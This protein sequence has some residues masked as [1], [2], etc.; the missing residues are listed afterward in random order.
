VPVVVHAFTDGRDVPPTDAKG[1]MPDFVAALDAGVTIGTVTGRYWSMDRDNRWERVG[2][3]YDVIVS[4][5]G[6]APGAAS[7]QEAIEAGYARKENDEFILPTAIAGYGGVKD[8]DGLLCANFRS[9]RAREILAALAAPD[10]A[11]ELCLG[12][13][14]GRAE[15]PKWADVAGM[16]VYSD[17]HSKYMSAIFPPKD[18]QV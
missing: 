16:V 5:Q 13:D 11:A 8:G 1:T 4:G 2:T 6:Q 17:A 3:G 7:A 15:Q 10:P 9:D 12:A 14:G 18:I